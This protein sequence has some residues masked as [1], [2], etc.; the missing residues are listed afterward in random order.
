[1]NRKELYTYIIMLFVLTLVACGPSPEEIAEQTAVAGTSVALSWTPTPM[2]TSTPIPYDIMVEVVDEGG[3]PIPNAKIISEEIYLADEKGKWSES[4]LEPDFS[5]KVWAQGYMAEPI[6]PTLD[7]GENTLRLELLPDPHGLK[8]EDLE[9]EGYELVFVEDFQDDLIDCQLDGNG[10]LF[11]DDS[12]E[13]NNLLIVDLRNLDAGFECG[14]GPTNI[15]DAIIEAD[16]RYPEIRYDDFKTDDYHNWQGF[17]IAFRDGFDVEGYPLLVPWGPTLQIRDYRNDEW[18]FPITVRQQIDENRWYTFSTKW[19]GPQIEAKIN[20]SVRF[21]YLK[22]PETANT[23]PAQIFAF[24]QA[25]IQFDN[26]KMWVP[27]E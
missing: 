7:P 8:L 22:A 1:M 13:G 14:F 16:F 2:P 6:S 11:S 10:N 19:D 21:T 4:L 17:G 25:Y 15:Q 3:E 27:V 26:I 5:A 12:A 24:S 9:K 20:G 18:E 23:D